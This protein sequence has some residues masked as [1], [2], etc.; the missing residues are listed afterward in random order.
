MLFK[1]YSLVVVHRLLLLQRM[2]SKVCGLQQLWP[3]G[4]VALRQL[5]PFQT[6]E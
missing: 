2:G 1:G 3:M 5:G 4:L 6:R